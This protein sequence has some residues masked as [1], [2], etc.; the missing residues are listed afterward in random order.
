[1]APAASRP[2]LPD[3]LTENILLRLDAAADV[4]RAAVACG[5]H[6]RIARHRCFQRQFRSLRPP[7]VLGLL[8][9]GGA[10]L[11]CAEPP[12]RSAPAARAVA[13]EGDFAFSFLPR[14]PAAFTDWRV[15]DARD[16]RVL[17]SRRSTEAAT[18][19]DLVICDPPHR[20]YVLI[21]PIPDEVVL[22]R[23]SAKM[24]SE[25]FL[26]AACEGEESKFQVI[27]NWISQYKID[28]FVFSSDT[29]K[30]CAATSISFLPSRLIAN[31]KVLRRYYV[32][33][34]FYWVHG[35]YGHMLVLDQIEMK[36]SIVAIPFDG[37]DYIYGIYQACESSPFSMLE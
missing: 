26:A 1:M 10:E 14:D 18:F 23:Y 6:L 19:V 32:G 4:V 3:E 35:P 27:Y 29:G 5:D 16:G 20:R 12:H 11:I 28:T 34:H 9:S 37:N 15:F 30:W 36:F 22:K 21:P 8:P 33:S 17:L 24:E 25:P 31:P 7:P 2:I 13:R